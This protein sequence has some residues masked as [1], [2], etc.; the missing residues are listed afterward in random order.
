MKHKGQGPQQKLGSV[1]KGLWGGSWNQ[2]G[3]PDTH[4]EAQET[5]RQTPWLLPSYCPSFSCHWQNLSENQLAREPEK[6]RLRVLALEYK[7]QERVG[8]M[9]EIINTT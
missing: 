2:G 1:Q 9:S 5:R 3:D 4:P 7:E 8:N 6:H